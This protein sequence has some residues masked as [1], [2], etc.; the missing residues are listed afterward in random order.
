MTNNNFN[1][2]N[3]NDYIDTANKVYDDMN[4][5]FLRR[6]AVLYI[7]YSSTNQHDESAEAQI[8][9]C[10][11]YAKKHNIVIIH[12]YKDLGISGT[13]TKNRDGFNQ[14]VKD[15]AK[16]LFDLVLVHKI[17]RFARS[18]EDYFANEKKLNKNGVEVIPV[19][20]PFDNSPMGKMIKT[21]MVGMAEMFSGN[22]S[23][24]V[25][26]KN[27]EYA[28]KGHYL[29]G[30]APF[31]YDN[32]NAKDENGREYKTVKINE[33]EA[34]VV[35]LIYQMYANRISLKQI[36]NELYRL[37]YKTRNGKNFTPKTVRDVIDKEIHKGTYTFSKTSKF[38]ME[39]I[40][41]EDNHE[42]IISKELWDKCQTIRCENKERTTSKQKSSHK[43][44]LTGTIYCNE[45][46][47]AFTGMGGSKELRYYACSGHRRNHKGFCSNS[48]YLRKETIENKIIE[49]ISDQIFTDN[50]IELYVKGIIENLSDNT[51]EAE[52][53]K[54]LEK[55]K[56]KLAR[57]KALIMDL[58]LDGEIDKLQLKERQSYVENDLEIIEKQLFELNVA[59]QP[60]D[61]KMV[62]K[63]L[64]YIQKN[65]HK[66]NGDE[67]ENFMRSIVSNIKVDSNKIDI[68][69][70]TFSPY[71]D[72]DKANIVDFSCDKS[73][74]R[75]EEVSLSQK[76]ITLL[77]LINGM[78]LGHIQV[79]R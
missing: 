41:I 21:M 67:K 52:R 13:S 48:K 60:I 24:E 31:G 8:R 22:L 57:K 2:N 33:K 73:T 23:N 14:M 72:D 3:K 19:D 59:L 4:K 50:N 7:R 28:R 9:A 27:R 1:N 38:N 11:E 30:F 36:V 77:K 64:K 56:K 53:L 34:V 42:P 15:S 79:L 37:G 12:I 66:L 5:E 61:D 17:D 62:R 20:S 65:L 70:K 6:K 75:L 68:Y 71:L 45:C 55:E 39:T 58:Y 29:G 78:Y 44:M 35:R 51:E 40:I 47:S 49:L 46:G 63:Y 18:T 43:Y 74:T 26:Y 10:E 54:E 69:F 32:I 25:T 16:G 76:G